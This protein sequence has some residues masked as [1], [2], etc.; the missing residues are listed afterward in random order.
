MSP[1]AARVQSSLCE[2]VLGKHARWRRDVVAVRQLVPDSDD[3][4]T[5]YGELPA[6]VMQAVE[7]VE[8]CGVGRGE[9]LA[10]VGDN[11]LEHVVLLLAASLQGFVV[12]QLDALQSPQAWAEMIRD[13][14]AN[15]FFVAPEI[16]R[17]FDVN[18][19]SHRLLMKTAVTFRLVLP[20][21]EE[22][23][24]AA[25]KIKAKLRASPGSLEDPWAILYTSGTT[26]GRKK[27][28]VRNQRGT[29]TGIFGHFAHMDMRPD[30]VYLLI[31]PSHGMST[32]FF[33]MM[34]LFHGASC[35]LVPR[36]RAGDGLF[37]LQ[38][39]ERHE[40]TFTTGGPS[41]L[42]SIV[43]A[44]KVTNSEFRAPN[45]RN[46]I[47]SGAMCPKV[48][49]DEIR[50][51]FS[52]TAFF[53]VYGSTELGIISILGPEEKNVGAGTV[54]REASGVPSIL[55]LDPETGEEV[56]TEGEIAATTPMRMIEYWQR[57]D[58]DKSSVTENGYFR[59]GD[60]ARVR[61]DGMITLLG[62]AD[63]RINLSD[64]SSFYPA[65]V[66]R[67]ILNAPGVSET[68]VFLSGNDELIAALRKSDSEILDSDIVE[69]VHG[70]C[71]KQLPNTQTP[72][73][74]AIY[75]GGDD[76]PRTATGKVVRAQLPEW[77]AQVV[78][79]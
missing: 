48:M 61:E 50:E 68:V 59:T 28:V 17:T 79:A 62:R 67:V 19:S 23:Q 52:Q 55:L 16:A 27:G 7:L 51:F 78:A 9:R 54:G 42:M 47:S 22:T 49:Q 45:L 35:V 43:E 37:L 44:A 1:T 66:E 63:D 31:Y 8:C 4:T 15:R 10:F 74:Y 26:S 69:T 30:D 77:F 32:F 56:E 38:A 41:H 6:L 53:D 24:E 2:E 11:S 14:Q 60:I 12:V 36:A 13:A 34:A 29:L 5:T 58:L 46:I 71:K 65:E 73:R 72:S 57:P 21:E 20:S 64:G 3:R 75:K 39:L 18:D 40:I 70:L 33:S 25:S 76:L